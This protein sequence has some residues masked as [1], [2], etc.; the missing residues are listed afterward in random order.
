MGNVHSTALSLLKLIAAIDLFRYRE[1]DIFVMTDEEKNV[2]TEHWPSKENIVSFV[3]V[4]C[5][6][7]HIHLHW[8]IQLR[9]MDNLVR[10][11][12]PGDAFVFYCVLLRHISFAR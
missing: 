5:S 2:G 12:T 7:L 11:A 9:A 1:Q 10:D 8:Q 3:L 4:G 6:R